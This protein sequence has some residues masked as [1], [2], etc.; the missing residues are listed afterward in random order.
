MGEPPGA[1]T[2]PRPLMRRFLSPFCLARPPQTHEKALDDNNVQDAYVRI[3][4]L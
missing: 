3:S 2:V 4:L 1:Y